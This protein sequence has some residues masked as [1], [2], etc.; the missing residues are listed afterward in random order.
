ML[1]IWN[2][3]K[4]AQSK[5]STSDAANRRVQVLAK[6]RERLE[7][8]TRK[9]EAEILAMASLNLS[10]MSILL[11]GTKEADQKRR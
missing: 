3:V 10:R 9:L 2:Q 11:T 1:R 8:Q 4:A 7:A 6:Q 5:P